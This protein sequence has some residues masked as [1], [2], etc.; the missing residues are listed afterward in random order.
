MTRSI[1]DILLNPIR[2]RIVKTIAHE[3]TMTSAEIC[4]S[5]RDVPRATLYRHISVLIEAGVL[6]VVAENKIRGS[7]ERTLALNIGNVTRYSTA[8]DEA[9]QALSF[10][11]NTYAKFERYFNKQNVVRGENILFLNN[12]V[13]MMD[14]Q[15][16]KSFLSEL[17]QLFLKYDYKAADGRKPRDIS[18]I[19]SP[20]EN[21]TS[22]SAIGQEKR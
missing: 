10:L 21:E 7:L 12:T 22:K 13:M 3:E 8:Q 18:I 20:V 15:E 19:S 14:D 16:F 11:I 1:Y 17:Q 5:I 9:Q 6:D 2:M 4:A